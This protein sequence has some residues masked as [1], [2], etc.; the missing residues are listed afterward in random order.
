MTDSIVRPKIRFVSSPLFI[1][2]PRLRR[3]EVRINRASLRDN[4]ETINRASPKGI[5]GG[6]IIEN[7]Y[8]SEV[9]FRP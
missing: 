7:I 8:F 1:N 5:I 6:K 4:R 9:H 3:I 2:R